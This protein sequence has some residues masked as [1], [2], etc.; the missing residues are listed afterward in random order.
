[1]SSS[2]E[3]ARGEA[4]EA[5]REKSQFREMRAE[6]L[7]RP[8]GE[9]LVFYVANPTDRFYALLNEALK[10]L[11]ESNPF[12]ERSTLKKP[13]RTP[14]QRLALP[15]TQLLRRVLGESLTVTRKTFENDFFARYT[16]SVLGAEQEITGNANHV[17]FGRRGSGKSSL[18][19]YLYHTLRPKEV[20]VAWIAMQP[21]AQRSD[22]EAAID[23]LI[24]L[25]E[26]LESSLAGG[27]DSFVAQLQ[28]LRGKSDTEIRTA[29]QRRVPAMR[30]LL[31]R[32]ASSSTMTIFLD[33]LHVVGD[34]LQPILLGLLY[35][36]ARDN[37]VF[38]K[39]SGV[40]QFTRTWDST[41]REGM[42][43]RNDLVPIRLDYNLTIPDKSLSHIK[44]ILDAHA[45]YCGLPDVGYIC[46]KG[47]MERLVWVAAGV[48]RDALSIFAQ[49]ITRATVADQRRVSITSINAAASEMAEDK[50]RDVEKDTTGY[51]DEER[52]ML[53]RIK[54]FC[55][56]EKRKNAFLVEINNDDREYQC[57]QRLIALRLLH[58]LHEGITPSTAGRRFVA[59]M[60]DYGFYVGIRAARSVDLFQREPK[61]LPVQELRRLPIFAPATR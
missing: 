17:V 8:D 37:N 47:V 28:E 45:A 15:E 35:G 16:P 27:T 1:M 20:P 22:S 30:R 26:Q 13:P 19:A 7:E 43:L 53:E 54:E 58:I 4:T 49:A 21:Y 44:G 2:L 29:L 36:M 32:V 48:P 51:H 57:V 50:L 40:E 12:K 41:S 38:L 52:S 59:L 23:V 42:E 31:G 3:A 24:E 18:L 5:F 34:S 39:I 11:P 33:D 25:L 14:A 9:Y 61:P 46:G 10:D 56:Q 60:L 55:V 6:V